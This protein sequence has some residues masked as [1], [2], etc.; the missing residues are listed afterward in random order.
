MVDSSADHVGAALQQRRSATADW[1]P[2]AFFS[3]KLEQAQMRYS[4]FDRELFA[5]VASIRHFHYMLEGRPFTIYTDHKPLMFALGKVS[6]PWT[7]MQSRQLSYVAEFTTDIR[8]IPG[9]ENIVADTLSRPPP[10]A[11]PA[12]ATGARRLRQ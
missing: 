4:A 3:K 8:H 5:C 7:A 9:S 6:E 2:L 1:Q 10:A 12:A 11:L